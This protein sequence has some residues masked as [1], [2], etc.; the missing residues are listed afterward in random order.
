MRRMSAG[1]VLIQ[2]YARCVSLELGVML[3]QA[4]VLALRDFLTECLRAGSSE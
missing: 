3:E 2:V 4:D 1:A